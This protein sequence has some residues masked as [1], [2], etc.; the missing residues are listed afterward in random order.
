MK[1]L[2]LYHLFTLPLCPKHRETFVLRIYMLKTLGTLKMDKSIRECTEFPV[3]LLVGFAMWLVGSWFPYPGLNLCSW[4]R[5]HGVL[6]AGLPGNSSSLFLNAIHAGLLS[7]FLWFLC[8]RAL[9]E[10]SAFLL[11]ISRSYSFS[12]VPFSS[13][14]PSVVIK[15]K[16]CK[17]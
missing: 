3:S 9:R 12:S 14:S 17:D 8:G 10:Y 16:M 7:V 11:L 2:T 1:K 15:E 5:K 6:T 4:Q 13:V